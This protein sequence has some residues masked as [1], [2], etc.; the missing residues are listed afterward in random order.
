MLLNNDAN[1]I[2]RF[3]NFIINKMRAA[4]IGTIILALESD[5]EKDI[6]HQISSFADEVK[7]I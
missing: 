3:S 6:I 5:I 7:R 4:D 2:G 1:T